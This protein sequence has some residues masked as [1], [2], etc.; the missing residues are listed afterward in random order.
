MLPPKNSLKSSNTTILKPHINLS[1]QSNDLQKVLDETKK[2]FMKIGSKK[3][4]DELNALTEQLE[5]QN[6]N[7]SLFNKC[8]SSPK[9]SVKS[10]N[11]SDS[12]KLSNNPST[13]NSLDYKNIICNNISELDGL[14]CKVENI[15]KML[16]ITPT[17]SSKKIPIESASSSN[18]LCSTKN[19]LDSSS[20][21]NINAEA[22]IMKDKNLLS[23]K[24]LLLRMNQIS[25]TGKGTVTKL[26]E[27]PKCVQ[28]SSCVSTPVSKKVNLHKLSDIKKS[29]AALQAANAMTAKNKIIQRNKTFCL[30]KESSEIGKQP[31]NELKSSKPSQASCILTPVAKRVRLQ[32]LSSIK[33]RVNGTKLIASKY[34]LVN[35]NPS[36]SSVMS[37]RNKYFKSGSAASPNS[38]NKGFQNAYK[39]PSVVKT[40]NCKYK[41]VNHVKTPKRFNNSLLKASTPK[42]LKK[43]KSETCLSTQK[44]K[45]ILKHTKVNYL[46]RSHS[47]SYS[48][49]KSNTHNLNSKY[50][51][52]NRPGSSKKLSKSVVRRT[53]S[54]VDYDLLLELAAEKELKEKESGIKPLRKRAVLMK[55]VYKTKNAIVNKNVC[56]SSGTKVA[57]M[58]KAKY[59]V[60]KRNAWQKQSFSKRF[61]GFKHYKGNT[62]L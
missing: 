15:A 12:A 55:R 33:K 38:F 54:G 2:V 1:T 29:L 31:A 47:K 3:Q 6:K 49:R 60:N 41:V 59:S 45:I 8:K 40:L 18:V 61:I 16:K 52:V 20:L 53:K 32:K 39:A 50:K 30:S 24:L 9:C 14:K 58:I 26:V 5:K 48:N 25:E 4:I 34:K 44:P 23:N 36:T 19:I 46:V 51:V 62:I 27:N 21:I 11:I 37:S 43:R 35:K 56:S 57:K 7:I 42:S 17:N 22:P 10:S 13:S 28:R